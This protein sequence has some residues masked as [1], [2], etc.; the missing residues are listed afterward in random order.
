MTEV[1]QLEDILKGFSSEKRRP[2]MSAPSLL[3]EYK[4]FLLMALERQPPLNFNQIAAV[5]NAKLKL[6]GRK[7]PEGVAVKFSRQTVYGFIRYHL[8]PIE[9]KRPRTQKQPRDGKP[10]FG[11]PNSGD[12][13]SK[14]VSSNPAPAGVKPKR[15]PVSLSRFHHREDPLRDQTNL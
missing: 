8:K 10:S 4:A 9:P 1:E 7:T 14:S 11:A 13:T 5:V 6:D 2:Y 3:H 12:L 15:E